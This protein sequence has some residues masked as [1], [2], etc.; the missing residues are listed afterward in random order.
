MILLS[1]WLAKRRVARLFRD[2]VYQKFWHGM[3]LTVTEGVFE[4]GPYHWIHMRP[5]EASV[6]KGNVI[7]PA[8]RP[9]KARRKKSRRS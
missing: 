4:E 6:V 1:G 2:A 3:T 9:R 5:F 7:E 8:P